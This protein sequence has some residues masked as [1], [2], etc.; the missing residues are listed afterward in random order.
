MIDHSGVVVFRVGKFRGQGN[1]SKLE[2][3][4]AGELM[5][6]VMV[7]ILRDSERY[8]E[9]RLIYA[10]SLVQERDLRCVFVNNQK[11]VQTSREGKSNYISLEILD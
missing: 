4:L 2:G 10:K 9:S 6:D 1:C 11:V 3:R 7:T 8:Q 5:S